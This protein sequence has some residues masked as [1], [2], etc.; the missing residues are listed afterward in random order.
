M[1]SLIPLSF[2]V[3]FSLP[4]YILIVIIVAIPFWILFNF[5]DQLVLFEPIWIFYLPEDAITGFILTT[6]IS[7]LMGILVSMNIYA[8]KTFQA[9]DW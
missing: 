4:M 6:L 5:L 7:I 3:V 9:Q 2:K 8:Y 1:T